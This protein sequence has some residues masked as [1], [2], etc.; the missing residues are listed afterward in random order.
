LRDV[1]ALRSELEAARRR[2]AELVGRLR[3]LESAPAPRPAATPEAPPEPAGA[4][5]LPVF[6]GEFYES[7]RKWDA[8]LVRGAFEKVLLLCQNP[9]HPGIDARPIQGADGLYRIFVAQDVRLF[10][11]R[12]PGGRLEIL[13]LIDREDLERYIRSYK[14]R[15]VP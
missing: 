1:A 14:A 7:I 8:R 10:Y 6:T 9:A 13:S 12:P 3:A 11:R 4:W 2:E 5:L 15:V